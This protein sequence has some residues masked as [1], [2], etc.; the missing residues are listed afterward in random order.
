MIKNIIFDFGGVLYD[1]DYELTSNQLS[2]LST[3]NKY[4]TTLDEMLEI[5]DLFEKG[6][7]NESEF[8]THLRDMFG[9]LNQNDNALDKAWN[10]M[11]IAIKPDAVEFLK[12]INKTFNTAL[13]SNTNSI[14]YR[15]FH[16][17]TEELENS[18]Q[19]V[20]FSHQIGM[21]KP[22]IEIYDYVCKNCGFKPEETLFID[23]NLVNVNGAISAKLQALHWKRNGELSELF[24][25]IKNI[26]HTKVI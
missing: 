4:V 24:N 25:T 20:F 15:R 10:A 1:L 18:F 19:F 8:R 5:P 3:I 6:L 9:I 17:E 13:L 21:R 2:E 26:T 12:E 23:D 14:H 22:D 16:Q 11:L 7:I